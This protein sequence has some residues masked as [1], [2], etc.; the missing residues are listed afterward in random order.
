MIYINIMSRALLR[1]GIPALIR[2][3]GMVGQETDMLFVKSNHLRRQEENSIIVYLSVSV[4]T[5]AVAG[6]RSYEQQEK[7]AK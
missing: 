4:E 7:E 1:K 6:L 3:N 5:P 2:V